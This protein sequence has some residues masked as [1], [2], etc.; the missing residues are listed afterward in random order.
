MFPCGGVVLPHRLDFPLYRWAK[1]TYHELVRFPGQQL[2]VVVFV[3]VP[4]SEPGTCAR[5]PRHRVARQQE[6]CSQ[7]PSPLPARQHGT[8]HE[9][10]PDGRRSRR[11][12][13]PPPSPRRRLAP[14]QGR[15][16][17]R[18]GGMALIFLPRN[19]ARPLRSIL[20]FL[21]YDRFERHRVTSR[22]C[23][24][25]ALEQGYSLPMARDTITPSA[26]F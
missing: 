24:A 9:S 22:R 14:G 1:S 3:P 16:G 17:G 2:V 4:S 19:L 12:A 7:S 26:K 15:G 5:V 10:H 11:Q 8:P 25:G 23:Q 6:R 13:R 20:L 18:R 21:C